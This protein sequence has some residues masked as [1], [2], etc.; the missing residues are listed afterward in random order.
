[1]EPEVNYRG[2]W[3]KR[4]AFEFSELP[5]PTDLCEYAQQFKDWFDELLAS[6][7]ETTLPFIHQVSV[8]LMKRYFQWRKHVPKN[9]RNLVGDRGHTCIF[10][11]F[12]QSYEQLA[13]LELSMTPKTQFF[14]QDPMLGGIF[15]GDTK[16]K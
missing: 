1:M 13:V 11:I 7:A 10:H 2:L 12:E 9:H 15:L 8:F 16:D 3:S 14:P 4:Q 6:E 5:E